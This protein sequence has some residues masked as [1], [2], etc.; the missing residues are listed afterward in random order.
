MRM[1][2]RS[3]ASGLA[4][5]AL[6]Q[7]GTVHATESADGDAIAYR[8]E[9]CSVS[10]D[11]LA[12]DLG[13]LFDASTQNPVPISYSARG[14]GLEAEADSGNTVT[15]VISSD[16]S[17]DLTIASGLTGHDAVYQWVPDV[18]R[19]EYAI[20]HIVSNGTEEV[21]S[22]RLV[23]A[24]SLIVHEKS[25]TDEEI[26]AAAT[27]ARGE[28][29]TLVSDVDYPWQPIEGPGDGLR[30]KASA[31]EG[32]TDTALAFAV[33]GCGA[34]D[35][36]YALDDGTLSVSVDG[37]EVR[38]YA[39]A[40]GWTADSLEIATY[41]AHSIVFLYHPA[42]TGRGSFRSARW[43]AKDMSLA[44]VSADG[45][46]LD[47]RDGVRSVKYKE[48]LFPFVYSAT[49]F[50]GLAGVEGETRSRVS[51]MRLMGEGWDYASWTG[52]EHV[53]AGSE[54]VLFEGPGESSVTWTPERGIW[55]AVFE[56]LSG[57]EVV[58]CESAIFDM[59]RLGNTGIVI[60]V[61]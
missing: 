16:V 29:F 41:G 19:R 51:V 44:E 31:T 23:G 3:L 48:D 21:S 38:S 11:N 50:T 14:W 30:S 49:N 9:L 34:F 6:L 55:K 52:S 5:L 20:C 45:L 47:L 43:H 15:L 58:H 24:L 17:G 32:K 4:A 1:I 57:E 26:L 2:V 61:K 54:R 13:E 56:I 28:P 39:V 8:S 36:E 22:R 40:A 46:V 12:L 53:V 59:H 27:G 42:G 18:P 37:V 7:P 10:V 25:A 33:E 35:F 60:L